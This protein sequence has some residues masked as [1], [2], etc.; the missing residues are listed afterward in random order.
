[1]KSSEAQEVE[2]EVYHPN[3]WLILFVGTLFLL[4]G[5]IWL[6]AIASC[7]PEFPSWILGIGAAVFAFL[8][9]LAS[10]SLAA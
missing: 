8:G 3:R 6:L 10:S 4:G 2:S 1:M 5:G 9:V 7:P